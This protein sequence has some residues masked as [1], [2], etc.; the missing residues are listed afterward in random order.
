VSNGDERAPHDTEAQPILPDTGQG[1][2]TV[3]D[4]L[5]DLVGLVSLTRPTYAE[6]VTVVNV[7]EA[8]THLSDLLARTERGEE[9]VIAR[10]GKPIARL[11]AVTGPPPRVFGGPPLTVPDDFDAPLPAEEMASWE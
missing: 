1:D 9:I 10:A 6:D 5:Q 7:Q 8:K 2:E 4:H 3:V 11:V